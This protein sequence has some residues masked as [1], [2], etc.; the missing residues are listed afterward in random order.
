MTRPQQ[1]WSRADFR[2][3][4]CGHRFTSAT[5]ADYNERRDVH[6]RFHV[7]VNTAN[8]DQLDELQLVIA[9]RMAEGTS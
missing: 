4:L 9:A 8:P 6:R 7:L 1:G 2:C 5:E 3:G